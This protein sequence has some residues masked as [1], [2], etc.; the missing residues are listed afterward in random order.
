[1][2]RRINMNGK[3]IIVP[4]LVMALVTVI[5]PPPAQADFLVLSVVLAATFLSTAFV[6]E[7]ARN[8]E[9]EATAK[10]TETNAILQA[11]VDKSMAS[12]SIP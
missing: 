6:V 8:G 2:E 4:L 12:P 9:N 10:Q 7:N 1:M 3:H 11:K 5:A